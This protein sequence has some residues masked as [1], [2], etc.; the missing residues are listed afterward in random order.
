M[1]VNIKAS[2]RRLRTQAT[3]TLDCWGSGYFS[4][5]H[6]PWTHNLLDPYL[7]CLIAKKPFKFGYIYILPKNWKEPKSRLLHYFLWKKLCYYELM[8]SGHVTS[9]FSMACP[10][11]TTHFH[12]Q[13]IRMDN[14]REKYSSFRHSTS[15]NW[16]I[17]CHGKLM[18][19]IKDCSNVSSGRVMLFTYLQMTS[20]LYFN[21]S[22]A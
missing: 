21:I 6:R 18:A 19:I 15:L 4:S 11:K 7:Q 13:D 9:L 5:P 12:P 2:S 22:S 14:E 20:Y 17:S 10:I 3:E 1:L 16:V 8:L